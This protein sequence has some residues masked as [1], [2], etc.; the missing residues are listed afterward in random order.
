MFG[1]LKK[2]FL[3]SGKENGRKFKRSIVISLIDALASALKIP[4]IMSVLMGVIE[5]KD[6]GKYILGSI[7]IM[8]VSIVV[9]ILCKMSST[10]LQTEG[11]YTTAA[12]KR[13]EMAEHLRYVPMGYFNSNSIGEIASVTTNTMENLGDVATRVVMLTTQGLLET[14]MIIL[15]ILLCDWRIALVSFAGV[16]IFLV[17][18]TVMQNAGKQASSAKIDCDTELINQIMEYIQ[19][20]SEVKSYNLIGKQTKRLNAANEACV[21][22]NV[23]MELAYVP[24]HFLQSVVTKLTGAAIIGL[25]AYFYINGSM[26]VLYAVGMSIAAFM[27]YG[28]LETMGTFSSLIHVVSVCVDKANA[29]LG[30]DTMDIDGKELNPENHDIEVKNIEFSYDKRKIIDGISLTIP[31]KT[32]TAIVGP[33]GGGKTTLCNLIARFWDVDS[34]EITLGG[35]NVKDY[36]MNS[37]MNNFS[38]VFQ[39]VYLFADTIEN[40]IKFGRPETTHEEVVEAAKKACCHDFISKLPDG[41]NTVIGEGGATLSG[42]EKQRIS[43]ARAIMKDSP[44][45]IL[46]EATANVDPENEKELT[47]AVDALTKEKTI[48]MIAHRLKTVRHADQIVVVDQGRIAQKGTHEELMK[49][50]GIYRRFVDSRELAVSWK[51]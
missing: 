39:N 24:Y 2:F 30:L 41:Y 43:I 19:G 4:A 12:F 38:F 34:G 17:I 26:S 50:D 7:A 45:I 46:D 25:S 32:T 9:G 18:N 22:A 21:R 11:G 44:I 14:S 10:V 28:S 31:E 47:L 1:V 6:L 5:G 33:S 36:S 20:I 42:G 51:I 13:I 15:M 16:A 27:L 35:T 3:F 37:L 49:Q 29:V 23:K 48:I 40:N 8:A